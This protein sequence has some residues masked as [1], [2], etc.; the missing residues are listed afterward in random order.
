MAIYPNRKVP[1]RETFSEKL[2]SSKSLSIEDS[3]FS[4]DKYYLTNNLL[5]IR[6]NHF[7]LALPLTIMA[8]NPNRKVP[9]R[10]TF[11]EKY[12]FSSGPFVAWCLSGSKYLNHEGTKAQ[13]NT[14]FYFTE[15]KPKSLSSLFPPHPDR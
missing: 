1:Y 8:I 5:R 2:I 3:S 13:R 9:Y 11:S 10:E 14:K 7:A 15:S 6:K 4:I 12:I